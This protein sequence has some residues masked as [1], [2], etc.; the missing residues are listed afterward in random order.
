MDFSNTVLIKSNLASL[1]RSLVAG[2][3]LYIYD[4]M[5]AYASWIDTIAVSITNESSKKDIYSI[6][7]HYKNFKKLLGIWN[8]W[9]PGIYDQVMSV[10][11]TRDG[12]KNVDKCRIRIYKQS[13]K[14]KIAK[15]AKD[16]N[17][18]L[19]QKFIPEYKESRKEY[20]RRWRA[21]K[22]LTIEVKKIEAM[23]LVVNEDNIVKE[24]SDGE[25]LVYKKQEEQWLIVRP[26]LG[27]IHE[28]TDEEHII[29]EIHAE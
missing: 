3:L 4:D 20:M 26:K 6:I 9:R 25:F 29:Y 28:I 16:H 19:D 22:S 21:R 2:D 11:Y 1:E 27:D 17:R 7:G 13:E 14:Y 5:N 8:S 23:S 12:W 15:K 18:Y 10:I 24:I